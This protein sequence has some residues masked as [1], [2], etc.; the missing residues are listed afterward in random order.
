LDIPDLFYGE[1]VGISFVSLNNSAVLR[2]NNLN[3][4]G[5]AFI[6]DIDIGGQTVASATV[7]Y[8]I[9]SSLYLNMP[10][11]VTYLGQTYCGIFTNGKVSF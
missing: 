4:S 10:F 5:P 8:G 3:V 7:A 9:G 6:M 2:Y 11:S 1:S